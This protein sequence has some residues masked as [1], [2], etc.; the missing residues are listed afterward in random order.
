MRYYKVFTQTGKAAK[1]IKVG[2]SWPAFLFPF[3]WLVFKGFGR[4]AL[5]VLGAGV[6]CTVLYELGNGLGQR[7]NAGGGLFVMFTAMALG[8][9]VQCYIAKE[10]NRWLAIQLEKRGYEQEYLVSGRNAREAVEKFLVS[11]PTGAAVAGSHHAS[12]SQ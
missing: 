7:G 11:Q 8:F 12:R 4:M 5:G 9:W 3:W 2:W 10:G 6:C 1:A